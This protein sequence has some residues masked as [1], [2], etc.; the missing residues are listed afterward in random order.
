MSE[1]RRCK[2]QSLKGWSWD[3]N[4]DAWEEG[5]DHLRRYAKKSG[6][7]LVRISYK[8]SDGYRVGQWVNVQ[9]THRND[10]SAERRQRLESLPGWVWNVDAAAW[11]EG[12]AQL[13][14]YCQTQ[15]T[16]RVPRSY[17]DPH[18]YKLAQWVQVQRTTKDSMPNERRLRLEQLK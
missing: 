5:F 14:K 4:E 13:K 16:A 18:G 3:P 11:E 1:D 2:L 17:I 6:T 8:E 15:G 12:F 7:A 9:R 10:L